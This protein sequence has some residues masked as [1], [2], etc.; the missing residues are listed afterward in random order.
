MA[1]FNAKAAR[2]KRPCPLWVDAFHRDTQHLAADEVGCYLLIL[3]AMWTRESCDFPDDDRRLAHIARVSLRLW[4]SRIGPIIRQFLSVDG[5]ALFSK[6]LREEA[7][8]VERQ[9]THQSERKKGDNSGKSL[10][11]NDSDKTADK[12]TVKP[13]HHP[14]QQPNLSSSSPPNA[15][16]PDHAPAREDDPPPRADLVAIPEDGVALYEAVL[17][18]VGLQNGVALPAYWM[19]PGAIVHCIHWRALGLYDNEIV[20]IARQSR[21]NHTDPPSG[22]KALDRAMTI[23]A[24]Y[25][26]GPKQQ[27]ARAGGQAHDRPSTRESTMRDV[28][29]AAAR[30]TT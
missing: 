9:V 12:S 14:S 18:A 30:G 27:Q 26:T 6:R 24:T 11:S 3:M 28:I 1:E 22:P 23:A 7:A 4:R 5:D 19:P 13:R 25:K 17:T 20:E 29:A 8:Y 10:K 15:R 16:A 21:K 2:A